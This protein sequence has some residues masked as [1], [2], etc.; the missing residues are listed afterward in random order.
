VWV[1]NVNNAVRSYK[2]IVWIPHEPQAIGEEPVLQR[3]NGTQEVTVDVYRDGSRRIRVTIET[4]IV[5]GPG[6]VGID[7]G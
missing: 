5:T 3:P 4:M 1:A 6:S 2:A 7:L